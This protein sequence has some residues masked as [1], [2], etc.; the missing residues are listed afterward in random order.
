[1][2]RVMD[3]PGWPPDGGAGYRNPRGGIFA[4]SLEQ[5]IV[6]DVIRIVKSNIEFNCMFE[7]NSVNY[8]LS[9]PNEETAK[10]VGA[11]LKNNI[12]KTLFS[13]GMIQIPE[14]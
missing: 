12:G 7:G 13:V 14:D 3:L 8:F 6:K 4:I 11:I 1:M 2:K 10:K 5:V 9:T